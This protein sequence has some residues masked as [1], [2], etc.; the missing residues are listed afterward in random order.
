[1]EFLEVWGQ[2]SGEAWPLGV[3]AQTRACVLLTQ[4]DLNAA[5]AA[6][7]RALAAFDP[8]SHGYERART[9]M[10]VA[11]VHRRRRQRVRAQEMLTL[12]R[13]EFSRLGAMGWRA[14]ADGEIRLLGLQHGHDD[15]LTPSERRIA[16]LAA[17]GLTNAAVATRLSISAK[18]VEAHLTR[19]YDKLGIHSRAELGRWMAQPAR[20]T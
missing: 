14:H 4:G 9:L 19:I 17:S 10:L 3:G 7:D 15:E 16:M 13:D 1:M 5:E 11:A 12:A 2:R 20:L 8:R 6:L 18:T